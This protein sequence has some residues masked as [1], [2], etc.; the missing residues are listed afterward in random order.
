MIQRKTTTRSKN[1]RQSSEQSESDSS[2]SVKKSHKVKEKIS[3]KKSNEQNRQCDS[4]QIK[5]E[6]KTSMYRYHNS[7]RIVCQNCW[8]SIDPIEDNTTTNK[9]LKSKISPNTEVKICSVFLKDILSYPATRNTRKNS[10]YTIEMS[11]NGEPIFVI[12][13]D[14]FEESSPTKK[15]ANN[16]T[17]RKTKQANVK[18]TKKQK[19]EEPIVSVKRSTRASSVQSNVSSIQAKDSVNKS[20]SE[21]AVKPDIERKPIRGRPRKTAQNLPSKEPQA[22][23]RTGAKSQSSGAQSTVTNIIEEPE[24]RTRTAISI[25]EEMKIL[26]SSKKRTRD[27]SASSSSSNDSSKRVKSSKVPDKLITEVTIEDDSD[28]SRPYTCNI[29]NNDFDN[30]TIGLTHELTH[31]KKPSV[32]LQKVRVSDED[33]D[34]E[35][36]IS[37]DS[38][39]INATSQSEQNTG[40]DNPASTDDSIV[41]KL[42]ENSEKV[43]VKSSE[44]LEKPEGSAENNKMEKIS[45]D[46]EQK[47]ESPALNSLPAN[48]EANNEENNRIEEV[49]LKNNGE[50]IT[51]N[52]ADEKKTEKQDDKVI[53]DK[54][55][56][57]EIDNENKINPLISE[58]DKKVEKAVEKPGENFNDDNSNDD[59]QIIEETTTPVKNNKG[60]DIKRDEGNEKPM[61]KESLKDPENEAKQEISCE[62]FENIEKSPEKAE[63]DLK[64]TDES[65][66]KANKNIT[67]PEIIDKIDENIENL[68]KSSEQ[69]D[70]NNKNTDKSSENADENVEVIDKSSDK[71]DENVEIIDKSSEKSGEN[72]KTNVDNVEETDKISNKSLECPEVAE[73]AAKT[74]ENNKIDEVDNNDTRDLNSSAAQDSEPHSKLCDSNEN[75]KKI[76]DDKEIIISDE[77][78]KNNENNKV[79]VC[80]PSLNSAIVEAS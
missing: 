17:K 9:N 18:T 74:G 53:D 16:P 15:V 47:T 8:V 13:D 51:T 66:E 6:K 27:K 57:T 26:A 78:S 29:C 64:N 12:S 34:D 72:D 43:L 36:I 32:I 70:K 11:K 5:I 69:A 38:L 60:D 35:T 3:P 25:M 77:K 79:D 50:K 44:E 62:N 7:G 23:T 59:L 4:C 28:N 40:N 54:L 10:S 1:L 61:T 63:K 71:V 58:D 37:D 21:S 68:D 30:R 46:D 80:S 39:Q 67:S 52:V 14:S 24:T 49:K 41:P 65:S 2:S 42:L 76:V 48:E 56:T 45:Q 75:S 73:V 31:S 19:I 33:N 22:R 20:L 55:E